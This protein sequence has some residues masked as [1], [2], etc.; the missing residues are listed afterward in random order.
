MLRTAI[1]SFF[2]HFIRWGLHASTVILALSLVAMGCGGRS[3]DGLLPADASVDRGSVGIEACLT[4]HAVPVEG[5]L[6]DGGQAVT[7]VSVAI[8]PPT[9]TLAIATKLT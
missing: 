2:G 4:D 8:T 6:A 7:L 5:G 9:S 1:I 3:D